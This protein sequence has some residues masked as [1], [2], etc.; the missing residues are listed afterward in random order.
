M[1]NIISGTLGASQSFSSILDTKVSSSPTQN[2]VPSTILPKVGQLPPGIFS[3]EVISVSD[4][5]YN[6]NIVGIDCVHHLIDGDGNEYYVNFR[7][8][9]PKD[10]DELVDVLRGYGLSGTLRSILPGIKEEVNIEPRSGSKTY[11]KIGNRK[12]A[13]NT[14]SSVLISAKKSTSLTKR[15]LLG[16]KTGGLTRPPVSQSLLIDD[17]DDAEFDDILEEDDD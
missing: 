16:K 7:L 17:D 6:D 9:S 10:V 11:L 8:F 14:S 12:L 3:S 2:S 5:V 13:V 4:A 15:G 1:S